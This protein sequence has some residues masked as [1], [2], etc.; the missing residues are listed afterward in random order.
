MRQPSDEKLEMSISLMVNVV[1]QI[2]TTEYHAILNTLLSTIIAA[3]VGML[4]PGYKSVSINLTILYQVNHS[5]S[6]LSS[7]PSCVT[8]RILN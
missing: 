7:K 3:D 8:G 1:T 6:Y 4:S 5:F 2:Q